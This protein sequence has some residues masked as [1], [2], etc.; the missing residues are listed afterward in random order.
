M[1]MFLC[2]LQL[3]SVLVILQGGALAAGN[4]SQKPENQDYF[5]VLADIPLM[6]DMK[7]LTDQS[8]VFDKAEGRVVGAVGFLSTSDTGRPIKFYETALAQLGWKPLKTGVFQR[9]NEQLVVKAE[10]LAQGALVR[11]QLSPLSR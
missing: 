1:K 6:P 3:V 11:F 5:S 9:N 2:L 4:N 10:K 7:E 8:F